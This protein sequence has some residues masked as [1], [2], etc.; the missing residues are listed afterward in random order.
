MFDP[1]YKKTKKIGNLILDK[2]TDIFNQKNELEYQ[3]DFS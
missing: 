1:K 2:F 3:E